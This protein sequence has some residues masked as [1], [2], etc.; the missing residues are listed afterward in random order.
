MPDQL[1]VTVVK[2][3]GEKQEF[4]YDKLITSILKTGV[5]MSEA[6]VLSTNLQNW[7]KSNSKN[8]QISSTEIRDKIIEFLSK[9]FSVEADN[10]QVYVKP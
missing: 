1:K 2:R 6:E 5:P 8:N 7:I 9:D 3:D 10:Y 4:S